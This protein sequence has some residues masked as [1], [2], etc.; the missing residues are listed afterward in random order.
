MKGRL[1]SFGESNTNNQRVPKFTSIL[2]SIL[3]KGNDYKIVYENIKSLSSPDVSEQ[4]LI[5]FMKNI[6]NYSL[7]SNTILEYFLTNNEYLILQ[8]LLDLNEVFLFNDL[9]KSFLAKDTIQDINYYKKSEYISLLFKNIRYSNIEDI[10][11]AFD[12]IYNSGTKLYYGELE[13]LIKKYPTL[14][15]ELGNKLSIFDDFLLDLIDY[16]KF[17]GEEKQCILESL[18][19]LE[20]GELMSKILTKLK[21]KN[22][23]SHVKSKV[24]ISML[25]KSLFIPF[26]DE[27]QQYVMYMKISPEKIDEYIQ[28]V[29]YAVYLL[30][31]QYRIYINE[32]DLERLKLCLADLGGDLESETKALEVEK[33]QIYNLIAEKIPEYISLQSGVVMNQISYNITKPYIEKDI[34][35]L[36]VNDDL[37]IQIHETISEQ[38]NLSKNDTN[39]YEFMDFL[40]MNEDNLLPYLYEDL[41]DGNP[42]Q[43]LSVFVILGNQY[44]SEVYARKLTKQGVDLNYMDDEGNTVL[45]L[46]IPG[47]V[48]NLFSS[49]LKSI[50]ILIKYGLDFDADSILYFLDNLNNN[51]T[52]SIDNTLSL[53]DLYLNSVTFDDNIL[54]VIYT[55]LNNSQFD[56]YNYIMSYLQDIIIEDEQ[57]RPIWFY[58]TVLSLIRNDL[59]Y[60]VSTIKYGENGNSEYNKYFELLIIILQKDSQKFKIKISQDLLDIMINTVS[61]ISQKELNINNTDNKIF[62][63]NEYKSTKAFVQSIIESSNLVLK[64]Q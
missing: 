23:F 31:S 36:L 46:V 40:K 4:V 17:L 28:L 45:E 49:Q 52:L 30:S 62:S 33:S 39:L 44:I 54:Q 59:I 32:D 20:N 63:I 43:R 6:Y 60:F 3:G 53:I 29:D 38:C 24:A 1:L 5:S 18:V 26:V 8:G 37:L 21:A 47:I 11:Q 48:D 35:K 15:Y 12:T 10:I 34:D 61:Q 9:L 19:Y 2:Q 51:I 56:I 41:L 64:K 16:G 42:L 27:I 57:G 58:G 13:I 7:N 14:K 55:T 25:V 50:Q 22:V